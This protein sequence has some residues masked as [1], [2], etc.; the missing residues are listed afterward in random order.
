MRHGG[1]DSPPGSRDRNEIFEEI[2]VSSTCLNSSAESQ[3]PNRTDPFRP[4][5][6][7][8]L[9]PYGLRVEG[10]MCPVYA[11]DA[12]R[13]R[14][15]WR[16]P[17]THARPAGIALSV[18]VEVDGVTVGE[19]ESV[20]S[21]DATSWMWTGAVLAERAIV[22]WRVGLVA[23]DSQVCWSE[24]AFFDIAIA[25]D[26]WEAD[27][28]T[29]P[30]WAAPEIDYNGPPPAVGVDFAAVGSPVRARL[31]ASAPGT[32]DIRLNGEPCTPDVLGLGYSVES[33]RLP[34]RAWDVIDCIRSG[35]NTLR[36]TVGP[37][38]AWVSPL[39]GRY[40]KLTTSALAPRLLLRL[41]IDYADGSRRSVV[42]GKDWMAGSGPVRMAHWYGGEDGDGRC[43]AVDGP[44]GDLDSGWLPVATLGSSDIHET[45]WAL[46]PPMQVVESVEPA[47]QEVVNDILMLD[48]GAN[49][50][51]RPRL[52]LTG[53]TE[54]QRIEIR[55]SELPPTSIGE[56]TV[57]LPV[58]D[59]YICREGNQEWSPQHVY[60]GFRYA[61][62]LGLG[63]ASA[64]VSL[65]VVSTTNPV[66]G[67]ATTSEPALNVLHQIIR[68][69]VQGNM[70]S[71]FT[72]CPNREKLG[73]IEQLH[74]CFS[75]VARSFDVEAHMRDT[76][77]LMRDA[78]LESGLIPS[79]VPMTTDFRGIAHDGDP[80]AFMDDICWGGAIAF[81]PLK[82]FAEYGDRRVLEEN[83]DA[84]L[85]YH[86]HVATRIENDMADFGLGDWIALDSSTP[87]GLVASYW[88]VRLLQATCRIA[89]ILGHNDIAEHME[90]TAH[91]VTK[92]LRLEFPGDGP[93]GWASGSQAS[94]ALALDLDLVA[95][96]NAASTTRALVEQVRTES[97][98]V[99]ENALPALLT[100]LHAAREDEVLADAVRDATPPGYGFQVAEGATTLA[101]TWQGPMLIVEGSSQNHFMLGMID[102]WIAEAVVGLSTG[103]STVA[104]DNAT[105]S[106]RRISGSNAASMWLETAKGRIHVSWDVD[107]GMVDVAIPLGCRMRIDLGELFEDGPPAETELGPGN[108]RW[109][110]S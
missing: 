11:I 74:L 92:R 95:Q 105:L 55:Y 56:S 5:P 84:L 67:G 50:V 9:N 42:S 93:D 32:L 45:W 58:W 60:H 85:R 31:Y 109:R 64:S 88:Y 104:W 103:S 33:V 24:F 29:A 82:H 106:P 98:T 7:G 76:L 63:S 101:E 91:A 87:R 35:V 18:T 107:E 10:R 34:A 96:E 46:R 17:A 13:P 86:S 94:I 81:L 48:F 23:H 77:Q 53:C 14:L 62:V 61:Q 30:D 28:I 6:D 102:D 69:S 16:L 59:S 49:L 38:I 43:I 97:L 19:H 2:A 78:Q 25:R 44:V 52:L 37:G 68:R 80:S 1:C 79:I 72:D 39:N 12:A 66:V 51:G 70:Y 65:E 3:A 21:S 89:E 54:G 4:L 110:A 20:L 15:S 36:V 27:W 99:G 47:C 73:W 100:V 26:S 41:E 108:W 71:V 22:T 40:T 90:A 8:P 57:R 83:W 75:V